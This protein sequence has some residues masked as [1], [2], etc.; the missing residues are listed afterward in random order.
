MK[1]T[2]SRF[3]AT[4]LVFAVLG[5]AIALLAPAASA[6]TK[7][8]AFVTLPKDAVA[9]HTITATKFNDGS[10]PQNQPT[11]V[12]VAVLDGSDQLVTNSP[13]TVTFKLAAGSGLASGSLSVTPKQTVNGVAT[14]GVGSLSIANA[15]EPLFTDY[16]L[17]PVSAKGPSITGDASTG[18]DI[19]ETEC[20][21]ACDVS[22][23]NDKDTY[24]AFES[25]TLTASSVGAA[26][27]PGFDCQILGYTPFFSDQ[28]F[29]HDY[30]GTG[31]VFLASHVTRLDMKK[32]S[33]NGQAHV[34]WCVGLETSDAWV[35]NEAPFQQQDTNGDGTPDL[36]VGLAP[37]CP[38][39][40]PKDFA[41]CITHQFGDGNGG[42]W[43]EGWLPGDPVRRT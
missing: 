9:G 2:R 23:R 4:T 19:W 14:F 30:D 5:G 33:N 43:T 8:L 35:H 42:S 24:S 10:D 39:Q 22:I 34:Q 6:A 27:L 36:Y 29:I 13:V 3:I 41:P 12:Q 28:V 18:F 7:H 1:H 15:N 32:S 17:V 11:F 38:S 40:N 21:G 37:P 20:T 26:S 31:P 16:E 25:G